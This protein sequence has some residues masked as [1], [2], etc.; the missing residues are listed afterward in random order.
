MTVKHNSKS[1]MNQSNGTLKMIKSYLT[2][3][4]L[5]VSISSP[6]IFKHLKLAFALGNIAC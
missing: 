6:R 3:S 1:T 2:W 5:A 4:Y